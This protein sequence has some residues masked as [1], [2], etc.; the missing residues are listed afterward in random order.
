M[1]NKLFFWF[2]I[3]CVVVFTTFQIHHIWTVSTLGLSVATLLLTTLFVLVGYVL[4]VNANKVQQTINSKRTVI[5]YKLGVFIYSL[6]TLSLLIKADMKWDETDSV[7]MVLFALSFLLIFPYMIISK[8]SFGDGVIRGL[9]AL[10]MRVIPHTLMGI[11]ILSVGG[12]G[13]SPVYIVFFHVLTLSRIIQISLT[14]SESGWNRHSTGLLVA[15]IG[16]ELSWTFVT[17]ACLF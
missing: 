9:L 13:L 1:K 8:L 4:S 6:I 11:K 3:M 2:Q 12:A 17:L 16:N 14:I 15:E 7:I 10:S 5:I